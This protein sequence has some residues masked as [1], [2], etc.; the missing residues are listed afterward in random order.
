MVW[1]MGQRPRPNRTQSTGATGLVLGLDRRLVW[2]W[3]RQVDLFGCGPDGLDGEVDL[4]G[5]GP[6]GLDGQVDLFGCG[7]D[8]L[9]GQVDLLGRAGRLNS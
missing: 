7:P 1:S 9:D 4:F 5:C 3:N 8:G 2:V 6:D